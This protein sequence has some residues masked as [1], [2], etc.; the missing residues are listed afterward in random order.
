M[1]LIVGR[2]QLFVTLASWVAVVVHL[3]LA[4]LEYVS[5]QMVS[6][7]TRCL[8]PAGLPRCWGVEVLLA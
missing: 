6:I 7:R 2:P 8:F 5:F 1:W 3:V 4:R